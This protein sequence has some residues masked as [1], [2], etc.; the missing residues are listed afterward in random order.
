VPESD[1]LYLLMGEF[2]MSFDMVSFDIVAATNFGEVDSDGAG[3]RDY[4]GFM[5]AGSVD[6]ALDM[7]TITVSGAYVSGD[8]EGDLDEDFQGLAGQTFSWAEII[9]DGYSYD[10]NASLAQIGGANRPSNMYYV[11]AGVD[12]KPTD[13]TTIMFDVYYVGMVEDRTIAG[14]EEDEIGIEVDARLTQKIYDNLSMTIIG[15][16]MFAEDGYGV[17][18][19]ADPNAASN[20]GDDAFHVGLGLD[21]KF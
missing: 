11:A 1:D 13:T 14:E 4:E 17:Y 12:L 20:S 8:D 21:F 7:A 6:I 19:P 15:A 18:D 2:G 16:Y 10:R 3:D 5:F 9:S